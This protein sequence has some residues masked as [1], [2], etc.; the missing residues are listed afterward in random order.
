MTDITLDFGICLKE[1]G[2]QPVVRQEYDLERIDAFLQDA[3]SIVC[4]TTVQPDPETDDTDRML[5]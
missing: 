2:A 3:Y 4:T 5:G 1:K